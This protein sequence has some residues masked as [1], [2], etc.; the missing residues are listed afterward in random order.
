[1]PSDPGL[2]PLQRWM[3]E[4]ITHP[5]DVHAAVAARS[6]TRL[7]QDV[8]DVVRPSKSLQPVQRIGVYH[9]MYMMR[10]VEAME[11]DYP[12]LA[13]YLGEDDFTELITGYVQ[14][15]PSRSF[16]LNRLGDHLPEYI[17]SLPK[18]RNRVFVH[19]L[20]TFELAM[21]QVFDEAEVAPMAA[22]SIAF[23]PPHALESL[24][25]AAIPALRMLTLDYDVD[26]AFQSF[27][28]DEQMRPQ[29]KKSWLAVYRRDYSVMRLP[30]SRAAFTF[31]RMLIAGETIGG[32]IE[33]FH[34]RFHRL[35]EQ[36]ELFGWFRDWSA[37]G[38]FAS[39][40]IS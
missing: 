30:L 8:E 4:V 18:I 13:Q 12:A 33:D 16:T 23:I 3:Q 17:A 28:D 11:V 2:L 1:M 10:M 37:A 38:L 21:T 6:A 36:D 32:A 22:D 26:A 24:R 15:H 40:T 27:R 31:L 14:Q 39:L 9:G 29:R 19:D 34:R 35:P 20:A 7:I 5:G 25:F